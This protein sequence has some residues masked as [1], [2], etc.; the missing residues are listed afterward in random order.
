MAVGQLNKN[1]NNITKLSSTQIKLTPVNRDESC[2]SSD[3][4]KN[5]IKQQINKSLCG[6]L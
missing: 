2:N 1:T 4:V 3:D 6:D 5:K